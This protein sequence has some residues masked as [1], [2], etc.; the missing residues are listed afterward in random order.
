M[1]ILRSRRFEKASRAHHDCHGHGDRTRNKQV[2]DYDKSLNN[3][4]QQILKSSKP[5][6]GLGEWPVPRSKAENDE[7][8]QAWLQQTRASH[9][10]PLGTGHERDHKPEHSKDQRRRYKREQFMLAEQSRSSTREARRRKRSRSVSEPPASSSK[11]T[12]HA[13]YGLKRKRYTI[14]DDKCGHIVWE[15]HRQISDEGS[16]KHIPQEVAGGRDRTEESATGHLFPRGS[17]H[18]R[19]KGRFHKSLT[20]RSSDTPVTKSRLDRSRKEDKELEELSVFFS[21]GTCGKETRG[22]RREFASH[23]REHDGVSRGLK[24]HFLPTQHERCRSF[25]SP[26]RSYSTISISQGEEVPRYSRSL[27]AVRSHDSGATPHDSSSEKARGGSAWSQQYVGQAVDLGP[28]ASCSRR[29]SSS[30]GA[31]TFSGA[32]S[33]RVVEAEANSPPQK[34]QNIRQRSRK[35]AAAQTE[36]TPEEAERHSMQSRRLDDHGMVE[37]QTTN[38]GY[39]VQEASPLPIVRSRENWSAPEWRQNA[40]SLERGSGFSLPDE[41][42]IPNRG[43]LLQSPGLPTEY[44]GSTRQSLALAGHHQID[45]YVDVPGNLGPENL[46][47]FIR[48]IEQEAATI[49]EQAAEHCVPF[50]SEFDMPSH[51]DRRPRAPSRAANLDEPNDA[52]FLPGK[53][54]LSLEP[55]MLTLESGGHPDYCPGALSSRPKIGSLWGSSLREEQE[56]YPWTAWRVGRRLY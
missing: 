54:W 42:E 35:D 39:R 49:S 22:E 10:K 23:E 28:E 30:H 50:R 11:A 31:A 27:P 56:E 43:F 16:R 2:A 18:V 45:D 53:N 17:K 48:R 8:V 52:A 51:L 3:R 25:L 44:Q 47:E 9:H 13:R 15:G 7:F 33:D 46:E 5:L 37:D 1:E 38:R 29:A 12:E 20:R 24:L 34:V 36:S 40:L 21:R 26:Q 55:D 41:S 6:E 32:R 14:G 4:P 19:R